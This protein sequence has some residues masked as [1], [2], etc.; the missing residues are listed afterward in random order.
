MVGVKLEIVIMVVKLVVVDG[1]LYRC[2]SCNV[3]SEMYFDIL[4]VL[5][6]SGG[7]LYNMVVDIYGFFEEGVSYLFFR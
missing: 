4:I 7:E 5:F 1:R 6:R 3:L 2:L